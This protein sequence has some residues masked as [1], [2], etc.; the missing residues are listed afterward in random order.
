MVRECFG[1]VQECVDSSC[2][3]F[4]YCKAYVDYH[5]AG[6]CPEFGFGFSTGSS[7][8]L[9]CKLYDVA[10]WEKC[11][12]ES[13]E[14]RSVTDVKI[15]RRGSIRSWVLEKLKRGIWSDEFSEEFEREFGRRDPLSFYVWEF[16]KYKGMKFEKRVEGKRVYYKLVEGNVETEGS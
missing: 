8:C 3:V 10:V 1:T 4:S 11:R 12:E 9:C 15:S 7:V 5:K 14:R 16:E 6:R 2:Y 13:K